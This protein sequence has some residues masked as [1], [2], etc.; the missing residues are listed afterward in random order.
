MTPSL[1]RKKTLPPAPPP[2]SGTTNSSGSLFSRRAKASPEPPQEAFHVDDFGVP[3]TRTA[4]REGDDDSDAGLELMFGYTPIATDVELGISE[5]G[6]AVAACSHELRTRGLDT[7]LILSTGSLDAQGSS[8]L[9]RS[10]LEDRQTWADELHLAPPLAI[11]S[12]LKWVLARLVNEQ[13]AHGF[14]PW[15]TYAQWKTIEQ[16]RLP[17][18]L[19]TVADSRQPRRTRSTAASASSAPCHERLATSSTC[20]SLSS[21]PSRHTRPRT[22]WCRAAAP[23]SSVPTSLA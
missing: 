16:S 18:T 12:F 9:I 10:Y 2:K 11:A 13:G 23:P 7:P 20:S 14:L 19:A 22:A 4:F 15:H 21:R 17:F 3:T 8:T 5:V 6:V 1:F